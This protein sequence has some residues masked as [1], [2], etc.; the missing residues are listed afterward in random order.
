MFTYRA[1]LSYSHADK[2]WA[3]WLHAALE[4]FRI[5]R[6]LVG[7]PTPVGPVPGSLKPIFRDRD[8]FAAGHSLTEQTR[9]A[10]AAA[11]FLVV[12]CSPHAAQSKYVDGEIRAFK[13]MGGA[14]RVIAVIV[15]GEPGDPARECFPP[16]LRFKVGADGGLTTEPEEP[17]AADARATGDGKQ[18]ALLK[19][20][21]GLIG[22]G[23]DD[24]RKREA[25][26]DNRRIKM[27]AAA[28]AVFAVVGLSAGFFYFQQRS[29]QAHEERRDRDLA[30]TKALVQR[31]IVAS[32]TE[33]GPGIE[34][35]V[36]DAVAAA[37][38]GAARG[39]DRLQRALDLLKA[40]KVED[41]VPLFRTVAEEKERTARSS[42][43]EAAEKERT[44]KARAQEAAAAYRN[45]GAITAI[46]DPKRALDAFTKAAELD[47]HDTESV[48]WIA[49]LHNDR[50]DRVEAERGFRRVLSAA[51]SDDEAPAAF[52]AHIGLGDIHVAHGDLDRALAEYGTARILAERLAKADP[53]DVVWQHALSAAYNRVG[54]VLL[55]EKKK[56]LPAALKSF[57]AG[58]AP[59]E[60]IA[61]ANPANAV[62]QRELAVSKQ[63]IGDV[64][65]A[66]GHLSEALKAYRDVLAL[67]EKRAK[68]EPANAL[69]QKDLAEADEQVG[70]VLAAQHNWPEALKVFH[71]S[72]AIREQYIKADPANA[73]WQSG[74]AGAYGKIG[75]VLAAQDNLS[76][77]LTDFRDGLAIIEPLAHRDPANDEWQSD[78]AAA[79]G[80]IGDVLAAQRKRPEALEAFRA[81]LA[82]RGRRATADPADPQ[83]QRDLA[84]THRAIGTELMKEPDDL[85]AALTAFR[86]ALAITER[87]TQRD[88][89]NVE[90]QEDLAG[91]ISRIGDV[92]WLLQ[93]LPEALAEFRRGREIM[94]RFATA[95][96]DDAQLR[97]RVKFFD[98]RIAQVEKQQRQK[99]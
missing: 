28:L 87:L 8:D 40:G 83:R 21:A 60:R 57:R 22:V 37:A 77:A 49:E 90:W 69:W 63:K 18:G 3:D 51:T 47:P 98:E 24:V 54:D 10:L 39:D 33:G 32:K 59:A 91:Y 58:L 11:Q 55:S 43:Q 65:L 48:F 19:L 9:A 88:P 79:Y 5:D 78:L 16:A 66:Q 4:S 80:K 92:L 64:L 45:L 15:D 62:L 31:L 75:D 96:P 44:A 99:P 6:D 27:T 74:L 29:Y 76:E 2:A 73:E 61:K 95:R 71:N 26:A 7:R 25:I 56:D 14:A 17:I 70:D 89:A 1:F 34:K 52:W 35:P 85:P 36:N 72:L 46:G 50:G 67:A 38:A 30:E 97:A 93:Q 41:A 82:V 42:A 94:V 13:A 84:A 53:T 20:V 23:L 86:D 81:S 12:I 68:N